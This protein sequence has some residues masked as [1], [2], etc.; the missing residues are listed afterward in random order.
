MHG[1][2]LIE[3]AIK[4]GQVA[5]SLIINFMKPF[6]AYFINNI[7]SFQSNEAKASVP[8]RRRIEHK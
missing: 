6:F 8:F 4:Q 7:F 1:G 3:T 2:D 5:Y